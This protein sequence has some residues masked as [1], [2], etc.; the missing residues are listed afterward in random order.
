LIYFSSRYY[1]NDMARIKPEMQP[2]SDLSSLSL[3]DFLLDSKFEFHLFHQIALER[4]YRPDQSLS[5]DVLKNVQHLF[6][7]IKDR[8]RQKLSFM[9][10]LFKKDNVNSSLQ[11]VTGEE[12]NYF[13]IKKVED[14]KNN[15][16]KQQYADYL[17]LVIAL[18]DATLTYYELWL[19]ERKRGE[20][21]GSEPSANF[22][23]KS[24][25]LSKGSK[26]WFIARHQVQC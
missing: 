15:W 26:C 6:A 3:R 10:T 14:G 7:P 22:I 18:N 13:F 9:E 12:S 2:Y 19:E 8:A 20:A 16:S 24:S 4:F 25:R 5:S 23:E 1:V 11:L 17:N 21:K